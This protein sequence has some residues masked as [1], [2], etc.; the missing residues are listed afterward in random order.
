MRMSVGVPR[1]AL[2]LTL[3][4][5]FAWADGRLPGG[6]AKTSVSGPTVFDTLEKARSR[7]PKEIVWLDI[8]TGKYHLSWD[9]AFGNTVPGS[10]ACL[11]EAVAA[12]DQLVETDDPTLKEFVRQLDYCEQKRNSI[13]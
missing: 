9:P 5:T 2:A 3:F 13:R 7:C 12:G 8:E 10:Y 6:G 11:T 4:A 1:L